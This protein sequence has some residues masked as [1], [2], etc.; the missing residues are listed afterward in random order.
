MV[1][2]SLNRLSSTRRNVSLVFILSGHSIVRA[3]IP[4]GTLLYHGR[5]TKEIPT[6]DWIAVDPEH[7][8][9]FAS[10]A[11]GTL[12]T[13][14]AM[15]DLRF[16]YFDGCSGNK[17]D[18]VVDSQDVLFWGEVDYDP[19]DGWAGEFVRFQKM[20]EWGEQYS[21]DGIVRMQHDLYVLPNLA[22]IRTQGVTITT[23]R[24][25]TVISRTEGLIWF[26]PHRL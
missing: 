6:R 5:A 16:I 15:R 22:H 7:S 4:P 3:S 1:H 12:F 21:L 11:N 18:G 2:L 26:L 20:C 19:H 13:Y 23:A 25:C 10:G 9:I 14:M 8:Q 24:S 17:F